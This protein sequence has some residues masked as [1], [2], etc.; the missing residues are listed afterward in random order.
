[1]PHL[2]Y[3]S[4]KDIFIYLAHYHH[5][6]IRFRL[7]FLKRILI[8]KKN[9][10]VS[11]NNLWPKSSMENTGLNLLC[12]LSA[13]WIITIYFSKIIFFVPFKSFPDSSGQ[14]PDRFIILKVCTKCLIPCFLFGF[15]PLFF[16]KILDVPIHFTSQKLCW[17]CI[18]PLEF[19]SLKAH[20]FMA[21]KSCKKLQFFPWLWSTI[22]FK[23]MRGGLLLLLNL[24]FWYHHSLNSLPKTD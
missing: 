15:A 1:M 8:W 3:L 19:F 21:Y 4:L 10:L 14:L 24:I 9:I 7:F 5:R 11:L 18:P 2:L 16:E 6:D 13:K 20:H 17:I 22:E 23:K 12:T